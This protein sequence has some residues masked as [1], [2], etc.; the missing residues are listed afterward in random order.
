MFNAESLN[1]RIL[2]ERVTFHNP[3]KDIVKYRQRTNL[4]MSSLA[5]RNGYYNVMNMF[6]MPGWKMNRVCSSRIKHT[7]RERS[8]YVRDMR[9]EF[10]RNSPLALLTVKF[11]SLWTWWGE[12][13]PLP[14][15]RFLIFFLFLSLSSNPISPNFTENFYGAA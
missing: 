15:F 2:L 3:V 7:R 6:R 14:L 10:R 4:I 11:R 1:E 5:V 9:L 12:S 13:S 8:N